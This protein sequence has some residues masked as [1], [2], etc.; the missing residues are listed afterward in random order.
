MTFPV[1]ARSPTVPQARPKVSMS[2]EAASSP[3]DGARHYGSRAFRE[4]CGRESVTVRDRDTTESRPRMV[5]TNNY[6]TAEKTNV[7]KRQ[8]PFWQVIRFRICVFGRF[9]E[10]ILGARKPLIGVRDS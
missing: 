2:R 6:A 3:G 9:V 8:M 7:F 4:T 10:R 1:A 5:E